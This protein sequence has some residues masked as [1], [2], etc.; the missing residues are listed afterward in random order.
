MNP[1]EELPDFT[2]LIIAERIDDKQRYLVDP[3]GVKL[4]RRADMLTD[5]I[6]ERAY[7]IT[8]VPDVKAADG[9]F[10]VNIDGSIFVFSDQRYS[11]NGLSAALQL[12]EVGSHTFVQMFGDTVGIDP[13]LLCFDNK[14]NAEAF[15]EK[16]QDIYRTER[17]SAYLTGARSLDG[18][19][20]FKAFLVCSAIALTIG[21]AA[22]LGKI[23]LTM[24]GRVL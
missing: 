3:I 2:D 6:C 8:A 22:F 5:N 17:A 21:A 14:A 18:W 24:A 7:K 20:V 9:G 10:M 23:G 16:V 1:H 12:Q 15:I 13:A 19:D 11:R 4:L